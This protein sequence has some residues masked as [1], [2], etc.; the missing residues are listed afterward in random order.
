MCWRIS[1]AWPVQD[2][3]RLPQR[4]NSSISSTITTHC[5]VQQ[6]RFMWVVHCLLTIDSDR[7]LTHQHSLVCRKT[8][9]CYVRQ[10]LAFITHVTTPVVSFICWLF[11]FPFLFWILQ[12]RNFAMSQQ[13]SKVSI[14]YFVRKNPWEKKLQISTSSSTVYLPNKWAPTLRI[15]WTSAT[16]YCHSKP[17]APTRSPGIISFV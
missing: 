8:R 13:E 7:D 5:L 4:S 1:L 6:V 14:P 9:R 16:I 2:D 12:I 3:W 15:L 17:G 11:P 10:A